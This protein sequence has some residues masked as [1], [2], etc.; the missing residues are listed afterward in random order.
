MSYPFAEIERK[1]QQRWDDRGTFKTR[2]DPS[3]R[4]LYVLDMFPYPSGAGLHV[5]HPEGYTATD[6]YCRYKRMNGCN[7]M[8]PMGWDAFGLPA[9]RYAMQTGIPPSITTQLN[10]STFKRQIRMLGLSYDWS[11]E[12]NTTDPAYYKWT[13]WIFLKIFNAWYDPVLDRARPI[14]ELEVP[15]GL[16]DSERYQYIADRR[17]AYRAEMPVNWCEAL[18]TVLANEEVDEWVEKGYTVERRLMRQWML[19]ITSYADRLEH[20]LS[21]LDWPSGIIEMQRN[22]IGRSEGA[23]IDFPVQGVNMSIRVFTTRP[24][25]IFGATY[26]VLAPEYA[27]V[28][29]VTT[30]EQ[31]PAVEDFRRLT[32]LKSDLE[33]TATGADKSGVFTGGYATNP[34]TGHPI[35]IWIA[36]YVLLTYG[37]GAIMAVPGHDERDFEFAGKYGLPV[38]EVVAGGD[39]SK[40]AFCGEG[41]AINSANEQV[42]L[43]GRPTIEAK[44]LILQWLVRN[45]LGRRAVNYKL[46]DWLFSRQRY[47]GEPFPLIYLEDGTVRDLPESALPVVLPELG[48]ARFQKGGESPLAAIES[49][50]KTTDPVSG[51]AARRETHTMPQWAGSCWYYLRYL[52]PRNEKEFVSRDQEKRWMPVDLYVGGAE[53]AVLHLLYARFWHKLLHD[54]GYLSTN[55]PFRKLVN[56]GTILGENGLKMSKSLDN[57]VN[58]DEVVGKYG[59]DSLR[60]FE[61]FMGPLADSKPWSTRGVEGVHRFLNRAFRMIVNEDGRVVPSIKDSA[62]LPGQERVL[63]E[64]VRKVTEDIEGLNFNTAISQ[65][66][67]F[68]NEFLNAEVKPRTAMETFVLLL[69]PFAPHLAEELWETMGHSEALAY[70]AWP[71]YDSAK[72]AVDTV[73]MVIQ[74]NGKV[75]SK[76]RVPVDTD[77]EALKTMVLDD[78]SVKRHLDGKNIVKIVVVKNKLVSLVIK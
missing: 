15:P 44:K 24:D 42:S 5:G 41:A 26:L 37:T 64:T 3:K 62:I 20:D 27:L 74:I 57:V 40:A 28:E 18:G 48:S 78:A 29:I 54:L 66:M 75:R 33:R 45:G 60:L 56:Q 69:S 1:W 22:W 43:N 68:V 2:D 34:A 7:V 73:E 61:M 16:S 65:L 12:I 53:H 13:Q 51:M 11:R 77:D 38:V 36:D 67:I 8:H 59:A 76:F 14:T 58:P 47:W 9:E 46:R 70:S 55:E 50:V 30:R 72:I 10:I 35:P 39:V 21:D 52:D 32:R 23:E 25:T 4:K 17:L 31:L 19:R 63:H 71:P 6:I 49:W